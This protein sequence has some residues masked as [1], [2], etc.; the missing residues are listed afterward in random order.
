MKYPIVEVKTKD[1]LWLHG[2]LVE[3]EAPKAVFIHIHGNASNFYEM[4]FMEPLSFGLSALG[5]SVL[6]TNNRG[7]GI[8]DVWDKKGAATEVFEESLLDIDAWIEFVL[9]KGYSKIFL[10][11]HSLGTEKVVYYMQKGKYKEKISALALLAPAGHRWRCFD[12]NYRPSKE[13]EERLEVQL[14]EARRLVKEGKGD[15][16]LLR[17]EYGGAMPKTPRSMLSMW[18]GDSEISKVLPFFSGRL[19]LFSKISVPIFAAIG[20]VLEYTGVPPKEA[21]QLMKKENPRTETHLVRGADHDFSEGC[22]DVARL[23]AEFVQRNIK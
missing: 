16:V 12:G 9:E 20:D 19:E 5:V 15:E 3:P 22:E 8:Y 18:G 21:L 11:G 2:L 1:G 14:G 23:V 7:T 13:R 10:S 6:S 4:D 17:T